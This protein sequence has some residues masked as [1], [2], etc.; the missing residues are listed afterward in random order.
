MITGDHIN[1]IRRLITMHVEVDA[2]RLE[3]GKEH[4]N[5]PIVTIQLANAVD[6]L[7]GTVRVL[8]EQLAQHNVI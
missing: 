5:Y 7:L 2:A 3:L 4:P 1:A 8:Y 6:E